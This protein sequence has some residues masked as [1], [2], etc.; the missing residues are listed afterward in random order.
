MEFPPQ[1][2]DVVVPKN[3]RSAPPHARNPLE[4]VVGL[5]ILD[6]VLVDKDEVVVE[7]IHP[8]FGSDSAESP[9]QSSASPVTLFAHAFP[10][11]SL[12]YTSIFHG[13]GINCSS[14]VESMKID[15]FAPE[16][17]IGDSVESVSSKVQA[18]LAGVARLCGSSLESITKECKKNSEALA[19]VFSAGLPDALLR[20]S[21]TAERQMRSLE[22]R[23]DLPERI[24]SVGSLTLYIAEQLFIEQC[25]R[26]EP[27]P[28]AGDGPS[29]DDE[30]PPQQLRSRRGTSRHNA[31]ISSRRSRT[32]ALAEA[33]QQGSDGLVASLQQRRGLL[34]S[35]MSRSRGASGAG[36]GSGIEDALNP[37]ADDLFFSR[38]PSPGFFGASD[39]AALLMGGAR[40][41]PSRHLFE[42]A[43]RSN[44]NNHHRAST[45]ERNSGHDQT[46]ALGAERLGGSKT[47]LE[48]ILRSNS[49]SG[50]SVV[51]SNTTFFQHIIR[52]GL[53]GNSLAWAKSILD[54]HVKK[55]PQKISSILKQ[56]Y[57]EE[58]TPILQLAVTFGCSADVVGLLL[59]CGAHV[60][61]SDVRM[62]V[63]TN[64]ADILALFLRHTSLPSDMDISKCS[65]EV[66]AVVE[67]ARE[68]QDRLDKKMRDSAGE[69]MVNM[70]K[71]LVDLGLIS[72]RHHTARLDSCSRSISEVLVGDVLLR[73]LQQAQTSEKK[74]EKSEF[75][76]ESRYSVE[77]KLDSH[78]ACGL[79]GSLPEHVLGEALF[80]TTEL[81]TN[82]LL[83]LEDFLCSKEMA[84]SSAGL[85]ALFSLL[86]KF[87]T[88]RTSSE[89]QRFGMLELVSYHDALASNRCAEALSSR[90][91]SQLVA[92]GESTRSQERGSE[93]S[94]DAISMPG[95]VQCPKKHTAVLHITRHSSFRC[96]LCGSKSDLL[97]VAPSALYNLIF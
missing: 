50:K 30:A 16:E 55:S 13:S 35:L 37:I 79:F 59:A 45:S 10:K 22:P 48:S 58:G 93:M 23:E 27:G 34:L 33:E 67:Q 28:S 1:P 43:S 84:D 68:R 76:E 7:S 70:L 24:A 80:G 5:V 69:F 38:L 57:D 14:E 12:E 96:D 94:V 89:L 15:T 95:L 20:A 52:V 56:A 64:Q 66:Q 53:W 61:S 51:P 72:R 83:L 85:T 40:D 2:G 29:P 92:A 32:A 60:T 91:S 77:E 19:N 81:A 25:R 78:P 71:R 90:M 46:A 63:E 18:D 44:N 21:E 97:P 62:A 41:G 88:L 73:A 42:A 74:V 4:S 75:G 87:P 31:S 36:D 26:P 86:S 49:T 47:Y 82:T 11:N 9:R 8:A 17:K 54:K 6:Q 65:E 3:L 39:R